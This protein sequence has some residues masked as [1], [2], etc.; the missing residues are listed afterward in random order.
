MPRSS[1]P[2]ENAL[3]SISEG[4]L[5]HGVMPEISFIF[6]FSFIFNLSLLFI[7]AFS[8]FYPIGPLCIDYGFQFSVFVGFLSVQMTGSLYLYLFLA[9]SC[10][11][12]LSFILSYSNVLFYFI[13]IS[14]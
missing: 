6:K 2:T 10:I 7:Y 5:Y 3:N 8:L 14:L 11:L 9:F 12:F 13:I 4:F 1:W